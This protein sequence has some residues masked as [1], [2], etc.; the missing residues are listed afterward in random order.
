MRKWAA[1]VA[2]RARFASAL[3]PEEAAANPGSLPV[4]CLVIHNKCDLRGAESLP[5]ASFKASSG[6]QS[7]TKGSCTLL[8]L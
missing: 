3:P 6:S 1:E 2:A 4:P 5:F 8:M 7:G